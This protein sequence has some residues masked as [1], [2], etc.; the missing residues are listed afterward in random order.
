[1]PRFLV[2]ARDG[3]FKRLGVIEQYTSLEVIAR[4]CDVGSWVLKVPGDYQGDLL[5]PG[6]GIVVWVDG[7]DQPVMSGPV[8]SIVHSWD[9]DEPGAGALTLSGVSDEQILF[10]RTTYPQPG[11]SIYEQ[12]IDA[13]SG[14]APVGTVIADLVNLN[15]GPGARGNR[16]VPGLTV[17]PS[18]AGRPVYWR[19]RFD[20][21]G[22]KANELALAHG[23]GWQIKQG[24][25]GQVVFSVYTPRDLSGTAVFSREIGNLASF[26]YSLTAPAATRFLAAAQ[27]EGRDRYVRAYIE[28]GSG[29]QADPNEVSGTYSFPEN[30]WSNYWPEQFIDRRDIPVAYNSSHEAINPDTGEPANLSDIEALDDAIAEDALAAHGRASLSLGPLDMPKLRFGQHYRLGDTVTAVI[31]GVTVTD[32]LREVR[33][34]DGEEGAKVVPIVGS[35]FASETPLIYRELKRVWNS[36]RKLEARR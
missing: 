24:A 27:G 20:N 3:N 11:N 35:S 31:N 21:L 15:A 36:L 26:S 18:T 17:T 8:S 23:V 5:K 32:I 1:M 33:L 29:L 22:A 16:R 30:G 4:F 10:G 14:Q 28:D 25:S 19:S 6:G 12:T 7:L 13:A 34:S 2:E 9:A